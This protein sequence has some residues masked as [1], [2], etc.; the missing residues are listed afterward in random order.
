MSIPKNARAANPEKLEAAYRKYYSIG[1]SVTW[2]K[3]A[4]QLTLGD[5]LKPIYESPYTVIESSTNYTVIR[6]TKEHDPH[7][8]YHIIQYTEDGYWSSFFASDTFKEKYK[9]IQHPGAR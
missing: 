2:S 9:R 5:A 1:R 7:H 4:Y 8:A 3:K 6:S